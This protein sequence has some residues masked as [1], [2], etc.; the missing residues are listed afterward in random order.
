MKNFS[1]FICLLLILLSA[2]SGS[3]TVIRVP[4]E[5]L[6]IQEAIDAAV[7]GDTVRVAEGTYTGEGNRDI[8][9]L[10]KAILLT[11]EEGPHATIIDCGGDPL[12]PHRGCV[13]QSGEGPG[14]VLEGFTITN[15]WHYTGGGIYCDFETSPIIRGNIITG[16]TTYWSGGGISCYA[17]S[18]TIEQNTIAANDGGWT[19][20]GIFCDWY[21]APAILGNTI[22]GNEAYG[23]GGILC[24]FHSDAVILGNTIRGN[25]ADHGGGIGVNRS[26]PLISDDTI[27]GNYARQYG[28][29]IGMDESLPVVSRSTVT[30]NSALWD[31]GGISCQNLS[32]S[33]VGGSIVWGNDAIFTDEVYLD[34]SSSIGIS[35]SDIDGGWEGEGNLQGDPLCVLPEHGDYRL[36]WDSPCI[37]SGHPDSLDADGTRSDMGAYP[38]DQDDHLTLYL[39]PDTTVV[40]QGGSLGVTYTMINRWPQ[41]E[42]FISIS[43]VVRPDGTVLN[44]LGPDHYTIPASF[45]AQIHIT[46]SI[47][48]GTPP[49]HYE[50]RSFV[51]LPPSSLYDHDRF[52]FSVTE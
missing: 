32:A 20:G 5:E 14:S 33:F 43:R 45:S 29:G 24:W 16:N 22:T 23:G 37:D 11:A 3:S 36:L 41:A 21:S 8:D 47:P 25:T 46:H 12:E 35:Y 44:V 10:G 28:G 50:Y 1:V 17:A 40:E 2:L 6:T 52:S 31:G 38:F 19:G 39:T 30:G 42:P 48:L 26:A 49:A 7:D 18:P 13:F 9:F 15:G 4:D 34:S 51:G 27:S